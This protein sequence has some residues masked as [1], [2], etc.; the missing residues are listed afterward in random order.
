MRAPR[1]PS[2]GLPQYKVPLHVLTLPSWLLR[3]AA[4]VRVD[5]GCAPSSAD[6]SEVPLLF[7]RQ[8][9]IM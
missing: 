3:E 1:H 5:G 2:A 8:A 4:R 9:L 7:M 6:G